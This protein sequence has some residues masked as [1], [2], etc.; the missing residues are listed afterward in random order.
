MN[1]NVKLICSDLD[2]TLLRDG[3]WE[4]LPEVYELIRALAAHGVRFCPA[5]GRQF[6]SIRKL[7]APV[8]EDCFYLSENGNVICDHTGKVLHRT[9][10]DRALAERIAEDFWN[11]CD[12][13][14]ELM[15]AGVRTSYLMGRGLG[16]G[17]EMER[18]GYEMAFVESPKEVPEDILKVSLFL[19]GGAEKWAGR[20]VPRWKEANAAVAGE[21]WIDT[22]GGNKGTGVLALCRILDIDPAQVMAFG[23]NY[24]DAPMLDV[25]GMPYI[26]QTAAAPLRA[27]YPNAPCPEQVLRALLEELEQE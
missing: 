19:P 14:G 26:M 17:E 4:P 25:V 7:F 22:T 13:E 23:D 5:S 21:K 1:K 12:G 3:R 2:G 24:N 8:A 27:K 18:Y 16:I 11:G 6:V 20:F 9:P 10:M 15:F